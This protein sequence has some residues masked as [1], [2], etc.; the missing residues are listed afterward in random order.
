MYAPL[1]ISVSNSLTATY[2][3]T[4]TYTFYFLLLLTRAINSISC[5]KGCAFNN[6]YN[7]NHVYKEFYSLLANLP[8]LYTCSLRF[9]FF[10]RIKNRISEYAFRKDG[11]F[12]NFGSRALAGRAVANLTINDKS[13]LLDLRTFVP[14]SLSRHPSLL[15]ATLLIARTAA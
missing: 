1:D 12:V 6:N 9:S 14:A 4:H 3:H 2:T 8:N 11:T 15:T 10:K 7:I 5:D 13:D